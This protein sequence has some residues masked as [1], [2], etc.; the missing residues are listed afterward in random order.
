[1]RT[2]RTASLTTLC[3][4]LLPLA[5]LGEQPV[6]RTQP[7]AADGRV[8]VEIVSGSLVVEGWD[9]SELRVTGSL[10]DDVE[11]LLITGDERSVS[12]RPKLPAGVR[13]RWGRGKL[14]A[15]LELRV[16]AG[17]ALDVET[18]SAPIKVT[19]VGGRLD[20][21]SVSG[22]VEVAGARSPVDVE[23]V[24]G[25]ITVTGAGVPVSV[26]SVSGSVSLE[27]VDGRVEAETVSGGIRVV[28]GEV[29]QAD[30]ETVSGPLSFSGR[31]GRGA[32]LDAGSHSGNV[33]LRLAGE[34]S[35]RF[36]VSTFSGSIH[37]ELGPP[38]ERTN[39]YGPGSQL[40]FTAGAGAAEV[41]IETFSGNVT[42][43]RQ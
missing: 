3:L 34:V 18:V 39:R 14:D 27:G 7:L 28:A 35:A 10:G 6:D 8:S 19:G 15:R 42:L 31:L 33:E 16:P 21:E 9:R 2:V 29:T 4:I 43:A 23:T 1:M 38:A 26:E 17:A 37:N 25:R 5:A 41:S 40:E 20:L 22:E 24:S 36:E 30:F 12:I 32:S 13:N 11:E